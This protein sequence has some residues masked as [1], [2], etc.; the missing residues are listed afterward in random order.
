MAFGREEM[1]KEGKEVVCQ[2]WCGLFENEK[3]EANYTISIDPTD[4]E[5]DTIVTIAESIK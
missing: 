5:V 2:K 1:E 4:I 3:V